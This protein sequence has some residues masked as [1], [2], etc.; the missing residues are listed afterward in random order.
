MRGTVAGLRSPHPLGPSLPSL[1][2]D[3]D[4]AQRFLSGLDEVLAPVFSTI[5]NFDAYLDPNLTPDDFLAWLAG[6][7]GIALDDGW[8]E[9]RRRAIV[10]RPR[11]VRGPGRRARDRGGGSL[12]RARPDPIRDPRRAHP[13]AFGARTGTPAARRP[14]GR[15]DRARAS[16]SHG[17]APVAGT[18]RSGPRA[19]RARLRGGRARGTP[20]PDAHA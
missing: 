3:D 16:G 19:R 7:V 9:P 10:A 12:A 1:Y 17:A 20:R 2:Q 14:A 11:S 18:E 8:D 6:W 4:F 5:D 13:R 15:N